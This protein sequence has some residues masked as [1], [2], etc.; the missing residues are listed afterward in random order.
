MIRKSV[1]DCLLVRNC[2]RAGAL[3]HSKQ[4]RKQAVKYTRLDKV[5]R[6]PSLSPLPSHLSIIPEH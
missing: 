6:S 2:F 5:G 4:M 1:P 3:Y